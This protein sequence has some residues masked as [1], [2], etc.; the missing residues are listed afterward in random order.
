MAAD[1]LA[2][3]LNRLAVPTEVGRDLAARLVALLAVLG[4]PAHLDT[5]GR[6]LAGDEPGV[7]P[8]PGP[9]VLAHGDLA[10]IAWPAR[11]ATLGLPLNSADTMLDALQD[12]LDEVGVYP[13]GDGTPR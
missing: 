4:I 8:A 2:L 11:S 12:L 6:V 13:P 7:A 1:T 3:S 10:V 5:P 9:H